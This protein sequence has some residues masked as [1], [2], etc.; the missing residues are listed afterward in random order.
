MDQDF[1]SC[2]QA[3]RTGGTCDGGLGLGVRGLGF[4]V[5]VFRA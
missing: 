5:F 1:S 2:L 3:A 4:R